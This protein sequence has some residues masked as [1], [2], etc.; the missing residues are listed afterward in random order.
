MW[1]EWWIVAAMEVKIGELEIVKSSD[2]FIH[3]RVG[4]G[5]EVIY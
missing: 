1:A 3:A 5:T 4:S 2:Q